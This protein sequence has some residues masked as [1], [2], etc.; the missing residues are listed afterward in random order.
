V[1]DSLWDSPE[2]VTDRVVGNAHLLLPIKT[3]MD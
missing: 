1:L 3:P 2:P